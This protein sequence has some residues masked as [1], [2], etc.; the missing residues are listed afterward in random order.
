[1]ADL[2]VSQ[3]KDI[4]ATLGGFVVRC[5]ELEQRVAELQQQVSIEQHTI[6]MLR[7][8]REQVTL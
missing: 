5:A 4:L 2:P 6:R 8:E 3:V 1:M 7:E